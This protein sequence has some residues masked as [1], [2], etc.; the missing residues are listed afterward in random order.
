MLKPRHTIIFL[1]LIVLLA[2]M[3]MAQDKEKIKN[4]AP[5]A[6]GSG[7]FFTTYVA[8]TIRPG[9]VSISVAAH[10]YNRDPNV[11]NYTVFPVSF[12]IGL[13]ERIEFFVSGEAYKRVDA[14]DIYEHKMYPSGLLLPSAALPGIPGSTYSQ[15]QT[16]FTGYYPAVGSNG[17]IGFYN[18]APF[19]DTGFGEGTGDLTF[20]MKINLMS[21]RRGDA[22]GIAIQPMLRMPTTGDKQNVL[23]G[24]TSGASDYGA[25]L[26]LTKNLARGA[27]LTG[28]IGGRFA[29]TYKGIERQDYINYGVG[30]DV[31]VPVS[32]TEV[33]VI[34]ELVGTK[35]LGDSMYMYQNIV[36]P[37]DAYA[38][39]RW[40]AADWATL[41]GAVN[42]HLK[43]ADGAG[44]GFQG[45]ERLGY[46]AQLAFHR[47]INEVPVVDCSAE[48]TT[49]T[50][51]DSVRITADASDPDDATLTYTWKASGGSISGDDAVATLDTSGLEA[52]NYEVVVHVT[53]G[54]NVASCSADITVEKRKMPPTI[55][56]N[57][58]TV[59]VTELKSVVLTAQASDP[60]GDALT[61][62]WA[63]DGSTVSNNSSEFEFGTA[64]RTLGNH[65]VKV[66]VTDVDDM[67]AS[68][69]F[70]VTINRRPNTPPSVDLTLDKNEVFAGQMVA[71]TAKAMDK[72]EDPLTYTWAVDGTRES[73]TTTA[74]DINTTGFAGGNHSVKVTVTDDRGASDSDTKNFKVTE[75]IVIPLDKLR[76]D[77][78]AKAQLDEIALKMQQTP[79][80]KAKLT[81]HTDDRG[82][83]NGNVKFGLKRAESVRSYL[84]KE[85]SIA[86]DRIETASAGEAEPVADNTTKEGRKENRRVIVELY[87]P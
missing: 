22:L 27:T 82:S 33:H 9:E 3:P 58:A 18:D 75:K 51:G 73:G 4:L 29:D 57:P 1:M 86:E 74:L 13:H 68:C 37:L 72:E 30:L 21:E 50:E 40:K 63:V 35:F 19:M 23:R 67:S 48:Q 39:L 34:G 26:I 38:G 32:D 8:D 62:S 16:G 84:V 79:E 77:N 42:V 65:T 44:G 41:S 46:F 25:D 24:L 10:S 31:P 6:N 15:L 17:Q 2:A 64:G 54:D 20:G 61:Y 14:D 78:K 55:N 43:T 47:K 12:A 70:A 80:L 11:L 28:N 36:S 59:A 69:E 83:E 52:G 87:V 49:V 85:H 53:D 76:P 60:N 45:A 7:G 71:A 5:S 66:T 81:G 56:C